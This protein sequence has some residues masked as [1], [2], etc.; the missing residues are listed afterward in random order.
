M[1]TKPRLNTKKNA[2]AAA[3]HILS[4]TL[5]GLFL[6]GCA[7]DS[8]TAPSSTQAVKSNDQDIHFLAFGDGGYHVDYPKQKH[9]SNPKNRQQFI[10]SEIEDWLEEKRPL[11]DFDHAPIYIYPGTDI[12]TERGGALPV[13][14]AMANYCKT[15]R[16]DF[17]IQ[18]GD[19]IYPDGADANDGKDD[20][21]R[22]NDLIL[23]PLVPL[24]EQVP[25]LKVYSSLGNHD[26]KSSRKGV[27]L[28]TKWMA[29]QDKFHMG[30]KGYYRYT[31][32]TPGNE[33]EFFVLDTNMLLAGQ[34][35]Y[36]VPL[37]DDGSEMPLAQALELGVAKLE[38]IEVH[39][40]PKNNEDVEQLSWLEKGLKESTAKWKIVYGHHILWSYGGSKYDEGHVLR[41]LLL[42]SLCEYADA[43]IAGHEHDLEL[44]TDDCSKYQ[45]AKRPKLPLIISGAASKMRGQ[46][47]TLAAF[48]ERAYP[49]MDIIWGKGFIWGFASI[50]LD[51]NNDTLNVNFFT[52]P[53]DGSGD[54]I[55]EQKFKFQHRSKSL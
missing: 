31:Q 12:A 49:E 33:V 39:E 4:I 29:K 11:A 17:G 5:F 43:Y 24:F 36:E 8:T 52:T 18:L 15:N 6:N 9:I 46:H 55:E 25:D 40:G 51:N 50:Q 32:G 42:P 26:W 19:N 23:K 28:Q 2:I 47:S 21:Q 10:V 54:L 7:T 41:K 30:D 35:Y 34:T 14:K 20:Q 16:C 3:K 37:N 22:M 1:T 38:G 44:L 53:R 13:G 48:Q 45:N 27:A